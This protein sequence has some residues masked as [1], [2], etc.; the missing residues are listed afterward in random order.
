MNNA[1][2]W[3]E[4][5]VTNLDRAICFYET[6]LG[7]SLRRENFNGT[8]MAIFPYAEKG[9]GGALVKSPNRKP[10]GDGGLVYLDATEKLDACLERT[11]RAGGEVVLPRTAIGDPG[12]IALVRDS[13]GNVIGLHSPR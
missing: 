3:F 9:V 10:S 11:Q 2:N 13:E 7:I 5:S 6:L 4:L 8:P 12:F 1:L